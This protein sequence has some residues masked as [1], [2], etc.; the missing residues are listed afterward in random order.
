MDEFLFDNEDADLQTL[1][2]GDLKEGFIETDADPEESSEKENISGNEVV[3]KEGNAL[4]DI[5]D[6]DEEVED[7]KYEEI[8]EEQTGSE[9]TKTQK[10]KEKPIETGKK[11]QENDEVVEQDVVTFLKEQGLIDVADE[12]KVPEDLGGFLLEKVNDKIKAK[13]KESISGLSA[14]TRNLISYEINGGKPED[15]VKKNK[16]GNVY[17]VSTKE[18]QAMF[19]YDYYKKKDLEEDEI[20]TQIKSL[21]KEGKLQEVAE[22]GYTKYL[23]EQEEKLK[24][25]EKDLAE[26][27]EKAKQYSLEYKNKLEGIIEEGKPLGQLR[28]KKIEK[29][30]Y[31]DYINT[32]VKHE[33]GETSTKLYRDI[34]EIIK[35]PRTMLQLVALL[36]NRDKQGDFDFSFM[37]KQIET[38][39]TKMIKTKLDNSSKDKLH[40]IEDNGLDITLEEWAKTLK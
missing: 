16:V 36:K 27:K 1:F 4:N 30:D 9:K 40:S 29:D 17:D 13:V 20:A 38:K 32:P 21:Y 19:L 22:K 7:I 25:A 2:E 35:N 3:L 34:Q 23:K 14:Y 8:Q 11:N 39:V 26:K 15:F 6:E 18:G 31:I 5:F 24:N 12:E 28:I 33:D 10:E 37:E